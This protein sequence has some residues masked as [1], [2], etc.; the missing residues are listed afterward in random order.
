M[1]VCLMRQFG[2]AEVFSYEDAPTPE[3][4][5]DHVVVK[6]A[7]CGLNRYDLYLRMGAIRKD[8]SMP[9]VMG[10]DVVGTVAAVGPNVTGLVEGQRVIVAPGFPV[11]PGDWDYEPVNQAPSYM[12]T[13]TKTWG[14]YAEYMQ[15]P[16]RFV[17]P[18]PTDL[19]HDQLATVPLC[20]VTAVHAVKT[21]GQVG[22]GRKVLVQA[23]ASGSGC[24][25]IQ[26]AKTLGGRVITTVGSRE[27]VAMVE[28][29]GAD[30]VILYNDED[31]VER[32]KAWT[33]G[34][35]VDVV[36][37][38]VGAGV[39]EANL[40]CLRV[41]GVM[42]NFGLVSGYKAEIDLLRFFFSQHT[43]KGSLMG[44]MDELNEGLRLVKEGRIKPFLDR[45]FPLRDAAAAH[46]YI[47]S[48][49]VQGSVVL[50]P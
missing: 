23:G 46:T 43:I 37:D 38:N 34:R 12:V 47:D 22:E 2:G 41:G 42:V 36:I 32:V 48:R 20:V 21:L 19:P 7:A 16:A 1:K 6:V 24:M 3:P 45:T 31:Q 4:Q 13:G 40:N 11:D 44:T 25:C 5:P 27:K 30:A 15:A 50:V 14:G 35:G 39:L 26:V 29:A 18:D 10:A 28:S 9:H 8:V 33:D 49:K 17:I